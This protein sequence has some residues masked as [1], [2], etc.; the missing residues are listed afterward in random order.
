MQYI[1]TNLINQVRQFRKKSTA[2]GVLPDEEI[3]RDVQS[4]STFV[5]K[6]WLIWLANCKR[7]K[8][9]WRKFELIFQ[10]IVSS[11][12]TSINKGLGEIGKNHP[13]E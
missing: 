3:R 7:E 4:F 13:P 9:R 11:S 6:N 1:T 12:S 2:L 5:D 8:P 10:Q